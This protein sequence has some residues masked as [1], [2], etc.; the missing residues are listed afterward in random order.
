ME[1]DLWSQPFPVTLS[2]SPPAISLPMVRGKLPFC[3]IV[4][5]HIS[6]NQ[7]ALPLQFKTNTGCLSAPKFP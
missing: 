4:N 3:F 6:Y 2:T 1:Q 5:I 7:S